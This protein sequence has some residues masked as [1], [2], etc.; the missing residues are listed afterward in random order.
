MQPLAVYQEIDP[1]ISCSDE[2]GAGL[3][4][5]AGVRQCHQPQPTAW[6]TLP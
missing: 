4:I 5:R 1:R 2:D 3:G 6:T